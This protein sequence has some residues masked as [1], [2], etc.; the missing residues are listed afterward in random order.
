MAVDEIR[1]TTIPPRGLSDSYLT[2]TTAP[3]AKKRARV[4]TKSTTSQALPDRLKEAIK[5]SAPAVQPKVAIKG[6]FS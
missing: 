6:E 3:P 5:L 2:G 1:Q 4:N